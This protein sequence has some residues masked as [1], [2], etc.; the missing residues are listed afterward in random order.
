[1]A[2]DKR[3]GKKILSNVENF[4]YPLII[5]GGHSIQNRGDWQYLAKNE[6]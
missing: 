5:T 3:M 6:R 4:K 1:V 2:E